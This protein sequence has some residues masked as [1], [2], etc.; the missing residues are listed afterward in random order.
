[1]KTN[2]AIEY[3]KENLE[4]FL[5]YMKEKYPFFNNSNIFLRDIQ[6]GVKHFYELK[7]EKLPYR[8]VEEI[9][10]ELI[11]MLESKGIL[12]KLNKNTW[13]LNYSKPE[14]VTIE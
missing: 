6:Y 11:K 2:T 9:S 10:R 8:N 4:T 13:I 5:S 14:N 12:T 7:N 3:L 1:M